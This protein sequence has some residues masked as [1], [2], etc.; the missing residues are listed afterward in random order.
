MKDRA[1]GRMA[2]GLRAKALCEQIY[3]H[4]PDEWKW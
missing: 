4:L 3:R 2:D 1:D